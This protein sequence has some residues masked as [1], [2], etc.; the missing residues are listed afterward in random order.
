MAEGKRS[1]GAKV[2]EP[3]CPERNEKNV[4]TLEGLAFGEQFSLEGFL[5]AEHIRT[6]LRR[7]C[8]FLKI[9]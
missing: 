4:I 2:F 3:C 5:N 9:R 6:R 8:S 1:V 7:G